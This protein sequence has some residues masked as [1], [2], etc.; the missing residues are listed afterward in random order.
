MKFEGVEMIRGVGAWI[1][2][3]SLLQMSKKEWKLRDL[4]MIRG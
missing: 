4:E 2:G 1:P 3:C